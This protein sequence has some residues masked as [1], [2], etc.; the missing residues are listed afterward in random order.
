MLLCAI[1]ALMPYYQKGSGLTF[2]TL[3]HNGRYMQDSVEKLFPKGLM[4]GVMVSIKFLRPFSH[5]GRAST[6]PEPVV[7]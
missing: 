4:I 6:R 7:L 2:D 3:E 5:D 1:I